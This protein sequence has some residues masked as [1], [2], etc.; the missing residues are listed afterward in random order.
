MNEGARG[1][2]RG[3]PGGG[4]PAITHLFSGKDD[5]PGSCE[6]IG[7]ILL[8][9]SSVRAPECAA[10]LNQATGERVV[11]AATLPRASTLLRAECYVAVVLH[12]YLLEA[13]PGEV[14]ATVA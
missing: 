7:M 4:S 14:E 5:W 9:T 11:A 1:G 6:R 12:Q 2:G 10:A 3:G 13:E 8:V